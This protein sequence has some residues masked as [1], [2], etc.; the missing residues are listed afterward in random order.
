[1]NIKTITI[2]AIIAATLSSV[3][4]THEGAT[5]IVKERMDTM[6]IM[7]KNIKLLVPMMQ[8]KSTYDAEVV[9]AAALE[10]KSHSGETMTKLFPKM[11]MDMPTNISKAKPAIWQEWEKF[12]ALS[13]QLYLYT[14]GLVLAA[15]NGLN[16]NAPAQDNT[17]MMGSSSAL[18]GGTINAIPT[19]DEL[20]AM[21]ADSVFKLVSNACSSCHTQ[22]RTD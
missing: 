18:M 17:S 19:L 16:N 15:E 10:I 12:S 5:G 3:A 21:S 4:F 20:S 7:G 11:E 2:G 14:D 8:G 13:D 6:S 1:M 9:K 22:F